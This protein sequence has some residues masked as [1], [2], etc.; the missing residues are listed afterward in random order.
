V[1]HVYIKILRY[2][3]GIIYI[4]SSIGKL[5][6]NRG[7]SKV[8]ENYQLIPDVLS[9]P[10]GLAFS[11]FELALGIM[12]LRNLHIL[13]SAYFTVLIQTFYMFAVTLTYFRGLE[14]DNCG[15][16]G[17]FW[18]RPLTSITLIEDAVLLMMA[19]AYLFMI[20]NKLKINNSMEGLN[21]R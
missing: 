10:S 17:V 15:C 13:I 1:K 6:D 16:F 21:G 18:A 2:F 12:L 14:L 4:V 9:L 5:L 3:F 7:F 20:K 8:I 11:L 19:I